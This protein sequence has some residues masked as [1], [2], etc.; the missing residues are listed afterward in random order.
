MHKEHFVQESLLKLFF[1]KC[2]LVQVSVSHKL[3]FI[4]QRVLEEGPDQVFQVRMF[5]EKPKEQG[6]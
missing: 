6:M 3:I 1:F 4:L 2:Y 5:R